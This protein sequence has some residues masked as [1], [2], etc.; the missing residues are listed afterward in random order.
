MPL[1]CARALDHEPRSL[2]LPDLD[3]MCEDHYLRSE[4]VAKPSRNFQAGVHT[5]MR[6]RGVRHPASGCRQRSRSPVWLRLVRVKKRGEITLGLQEKL[7]RGIPE[8][9]SFR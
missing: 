7:A 2:M 6:E 3:K 9:L 8:L 1:T 4:I 5:P